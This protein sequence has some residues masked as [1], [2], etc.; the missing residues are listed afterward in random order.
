MN[1][2]KCHSALIRKALVQSQSISDDFDLIKTI[3]VSRKFEI[4]D[5]FNDSA[6][7]NF[8]YEELDELLPFIRRCRFHPDS[9]I[10]NDEV[11]SIA[12]LIKFI[13]S[14]LSNLPPANEDIISIIIYIFLTMRYIKSDFNLWENLNLENPI[15]HSLLGLLF[16]IL[17]NPDFIQMKSDNAG[18]FEREVFDLYKVGLEEQDFVKIYSFVDILLRSSVIDVNCFIE[19]T[20]S[21][22]FWADQDRLINTFNEQNDVIQ[23]YYLL[24]GLTISEKLLICSKTS[25]QFVLFECIHEVVNNRMDLSLTEVD[26]LAQCIV[27]FA[28]EFES[29]WESF[30]SYFNSY[31]IRFPKL[32]QSL[33]QALA[34][35]D[36]NQ[37]R[38]YIDS[39]KITEHGTDSLH[40][41]NCVKAFLEKSQPNKQYFLLNL[42]FQRWDAFMSLGLEGSFNVF[43][44]FKTEI[45]S[46]TIYYISNNFSEQ[47][48]VDE[49]EKIIP[50]L[51]S[52][53][54]IWFASKILQL[55]YFHIFL[56]KLL[57][58]SVAWKNCGH[59]IKKYPYLSSDLKQFF[60]NKHIFCTQ[61]FTNQTIDHIEQMRMHFDL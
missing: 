21:F 46:L 57:V 56:S 1:M 44:L 30:L 58:F 54:S 27:R 25:N 43:N 61:D 47:K 60:S 3:F 23:T 6:T 17:D 16:A 24:Q 48:L 11:Q 52:I 40:I 50:R 8:F 28:Q 7:V 38:K 32:Q 53:N 9:S 18:I 2:H 22:L 15:D 26:M 37:L 49:I 31:P 33:G 20:V 12:R 39:L 14:T 13:T 29:S 19:E 34:Y 55:S 4:K 59:S 10:S 42:F 51:K 35:L 41:C 45:F 5:I 36:E